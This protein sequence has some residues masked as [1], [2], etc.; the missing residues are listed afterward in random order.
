MNTHSFPPE[1]A[2]GPDDQAAAWLAREDRG[3]TPRE[4]DEFFQWLA[5]NPRNGEL[6]ARHRRTVAGLRLLA[7]WRPEH[8]AKPNPDLLANPVARTPAAPRRAPAWVG[9]LALAA[10]AVLAFVFWRPQPAPS[11]ES[12]VA[13]APVLLRKVLEDGSSIDLAPGAQVEIAYTAQQRG[14]RLV[15]GGATFNVAKNPARPFVVE[16]SGVRVRAVGTAFNVDLRDASV[17]VLVT[18]GRVAVQD[19]PA[20]TREAAEV[21]LDAGERTSVNLRDSVVPVVE[22][23]PPGDLVRV[24]AWQPRELEFNDTPLAQVVAEFNS[25]NRLKLVIDD[26]QLASLPVGASL[27]SDNVDGFVRL[28]EASFRVQAERRADG[29]IVLRRAE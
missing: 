8:G 20:P 2:P 12:P 19:R 5:E 10:C 28:L 1:P 15:R 11:A 14:V 22:V 21:F 25:G 17:A 24:Q 4:Q 13:A 29:V 7:Q 27:H 9:P 3:F 16:A 26:L 6:L 18:E 23:A